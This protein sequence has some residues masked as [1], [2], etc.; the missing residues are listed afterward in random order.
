MRDIKD[1][2][3][4]GL[5]EGLGEVLGARL[6]RWGYEY[7]NYTLIHRLLKYNI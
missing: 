4:A 6:V 2:V 7:T 3:G 1:R 5:G